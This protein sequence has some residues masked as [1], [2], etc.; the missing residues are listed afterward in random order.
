MGLS[1]KF[2]NIFKGRYK[3]YLNLT[4]VLCIGV[5]S[6]SLSNNLNPQLQHHYFDKHLDS[7]KFAVVELLNTSV[8]SKTIKAEAKCIQLIDSNNNRINT[9]GKIMTYIQLDSHYTS[10]LMAGNIL[11]IPVYLIQKYQAPKN[12]NEFDF[13]NYMRLNGIYYNSYL[14]NKQWLIADNKQHFFKAK[15]YQIR[16]YFLSCLDYL[17]KQEKALASALLLGFKENLNDEI[18]SDYSS[19]G[20]MHVLAVSG[21]HVGILSYV[22]GFLLSFLRRYKWGEYLRIGLLISGIWFYAILAGLPPSVQRAA[23][24][25][26]ILQLVET[27]NKLSP[28]INNVIIAAIIMLVINPNILFHVGFQLSFIAVAGIILWQPYIQN[29][30]PFYKLKNKWLRYP[31]KL[32]WQVESV[33]IAAQLSTFPIAILYFHQFPNLFLISNLVVITGATFIMWIGFL[34]FFLASLPQIAIIV[35]SRDYIQILFEWILWTCNAGVKFL[36]E[37]PHAHIPFIHIDVLDTALLFGIAWPFLYAIMYRNKKAFYL[38]LVIM[39]TASSKALYESL[40]KANNEVVVFATNAGSAVAISQNNTSLL[41]ADS[42]NRDA[43][44][45]NTRIYL[46]SRK[47]DIYTMPI[48]PVEKLKFTEIDNNLI[49][50]YPSKTYEIDPNAQIIVLDKNSAYAIDSTYKHQQVV[51]DNSVRN[52]EV[53][54]FLPKFAAAHFVSKKGA[55]IKN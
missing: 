41:F 37:I 43:L 52:W 32:F 35:F 34:L 4:L 12:P 1:W 38:S 3:L 6:Y 13:A 39:L 45:F 21:L 26:S 42:L 28:G 46:S 30:I 2:L 22:L 31:I 5:I 50:F 53:V 20:A 44:V 48:E 24:M 55:F 36:A 25:F 18:I 47:Q 16:Q 27:R 14:S 17:P 51:I 10:T 54:K 11:V 8:R 7:A 33:A 19:T 29:L 23:L 49:Q 9:T 40:H 15:M